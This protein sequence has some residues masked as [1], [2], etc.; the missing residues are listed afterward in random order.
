MGM[1]DTY[2]YLNLPGGDGSQV[3]Q[4]TISVISAV[5]PTA[6]PENV[7]DVGIDN[8]SNDVNITMPLASSG[9]RIILWVLG[10]GNDL[11]LQPD[12]T[13]QFAGQA[14]GASITILNAVGTVLLSGRGT[15]WQAVFVASALVNFVLE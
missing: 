7:T 5:G 11:I 4:Q 10:T 3:T 6:L 12:A 14:L 9:R 13:N 15:T 8:N 2:P 1:H